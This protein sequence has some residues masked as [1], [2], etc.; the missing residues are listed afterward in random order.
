MNGSC[1]P[2]EDRRGQQRAWFA[3]R[4]SSGAVLAPMAGY[5]DAPFR[6][7][8]H[9]FGAAW[10]VSEMVSAKALALQPHDDACVRVSAP[11]PGEPR[12]VVQL[13]AAEP[14]LAARAIERLERVHRPAAFDLNL[15]CPVRKVINRGCGS[16]LLREPRRAAAVLAAMV[17][18]ASVPVSAKLRLGVDRDV[19]V[20]VAQALVEAGAAALA[21]H[22]RTAHQ[23]FDGRADWD[24][25]ARVA[26][27]VDVPVLGSGDVVD[28]HGYE[29]A[30]AAGLG[31]MVARGAI[32]RPWLFAQLRGAEA[33]G[34]DAIVTVVWR[35]ARDHTAWYGGP[36]PLRRLRG[37]L[38]AYVAALAA[39]PGPRLASEALRAAVVRVDT[40]DDLRAALLDHARVSVDATLERLD[41]RW[42]DLATAPLLTLPDEA[43]QRA[44]QAFSGPSRTR[45]PV[46]GAGPGRPERG[47]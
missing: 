16:E 41:G 31:V 6:R 32:G 29:R 28:A 3:E 9:R 27:A 39:A 36:R 30:R 43:R 23:R 34:R 24:A 33:P 20:E 2:V 8:A 15:G 12:A 13:F 42:R 18:A 22:G 47:R 14:D 45:S 4:V 21:V 1:A 25:I 7:L 46:A 40:L 11:Y 37:H 10:A 5:S 35:H 38:A 44:P 26:A 19:A 17:G